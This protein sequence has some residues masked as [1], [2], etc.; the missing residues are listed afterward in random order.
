MVN[1]ALSMCGCGLVLNLPSD[2]VW[3]DLP[4]YQTPSC[5]VSPYTTSGASTTMV[6]G[7]ADRRGR[8][9]P[10]KPCI[11]SVVPPL[12]KPVTRKLSVS[13]TVIGSV[14]EV[15]TTVFAAVSTNV[16]AVTLRMVNAP[17]F[18]R[19]P[20]VLVVPDTWM[21]SPA[22]NPSVIQLPPSV[23][24]IL[25]PAALRAKTTLGKVHSPVKAS[26]WPTE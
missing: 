11:S 22:T 19:L 1:D 15:G 16:L 7:T 17:L 3:Y 4:L 9:W 20:L 10:G 8:F 2:C 26:C 5:V 21:D 6:M 24:V 18:V 14:V 12:A 23:R 13:S 25:S